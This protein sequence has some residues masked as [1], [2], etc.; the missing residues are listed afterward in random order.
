MTSSTGRGSGGGG[1]KR[2]VVV[3]D[4]VVPAGWSIEVSEGEDERLIR[5]IN[6]D[7]FTTAENVSE[8]LKLLF[9]VVS[10][11]GVGVGCDRG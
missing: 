8:E 2:E 9:G 4:E 10:E 3:G 1:G 6:N 5:G 7:F 11:G